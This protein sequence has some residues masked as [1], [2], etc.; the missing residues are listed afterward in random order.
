MLRP[1]GT[2]QKKARSLQAGVV[3]MRETGAGV[4]KVRARGGRREQTVNPCGR[5]R[6]S[7]RQVENKGGPSS[8]MGD[9]EP[10]T[11]VRVHP[12]GSGSSERF[13]TK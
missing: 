1:V 7:F 5:S 4:N 11:K 12:A 8:I 2:G 6:G 9:L 13:S 3:R 10:Q